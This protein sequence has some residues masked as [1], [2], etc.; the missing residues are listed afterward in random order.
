VATA[1]WSAEAAASGWSRQAGVEL[2]DGEAA[3]G[4][5][6]AWRSRPSSTVQG[7]AEDEAAT[8]RTWERRRRA[9]AWEVAIGVGGGAWRRLVWRS[10][11]MEARVPPTD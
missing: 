9:A 1:G 6:L 8:C 11:R 3:V 5:D 4:V 7:E 2:V 10:R